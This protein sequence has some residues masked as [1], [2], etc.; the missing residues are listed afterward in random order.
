M[1]N[2]VMDYLEQ[3]EKLYKYFE[4]NLEINLLRKV[5]DMKHNFNNDYNLIACFLKD[6]L[7]VVANKKIADSSLYDEF[8]LYFEKEIK[9]LPKEFIINEFIKYSKYYLSIVFEDFT[10]NDILIA[11]STV[12]ACF[13]IEYYP[14]LMKTMDKYYSNL[15]D[16]K[17]FKALL[18][19]IVDVA[20]KNFEEYDIVGIEP[21]E[22]E[23]Q[24]EL[25]AQTKIQIQERLLV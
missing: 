6:Y 15:I 25:S 2:V 14:I 3:T 5:I 23:Q 10:D 13:A 18:D 24:V 9:L 8:V 20:I 17:Q 4:F 7:V 16:K 19:S 11:V 1:Y 21:V 22:L 12:N